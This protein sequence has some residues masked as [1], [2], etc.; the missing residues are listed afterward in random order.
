MLVTPSHVSAI[1]ATTTKSPQKG[2][3]NY[4]SCYDQ[5]TTRTQVITALCG[6]TI[7]RMCDIATTISAN[8]NANKTVDYEFLVVLVHRCSRVQGESIDINVRPRIGLSS[9]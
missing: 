2:T 3:Y 6:V 5:A 8:S 7:F 1:A 9:Q 4:E